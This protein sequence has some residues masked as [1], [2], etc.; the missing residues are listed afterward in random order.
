MLNM[1]NL[2]SLYPELEP[3]DSG[4][5]KVSDIHQIYYE[6]CGKKDGKPALF[7]H[8]GPGGGVGMNDRRLFDPEVYRVVL[9]DQRG[10]GKSTPP[11]E[12]K[13]NTTWNLVNDI[14]KL[15]DHLG[16]EKWGVVFGGSWGSSL[17]LIYAQ[18]HPDRVKAMVLRGIF[19]VRR[20][21]IEWFYQ[22]GAGNIYPDH[23]EK[24]VEPIPEAE[25]G[26]LIKAYYKQLTSEDRTV[27]VRAARAWSTWEM[28]TSSLYLNPEALKR[29]EDDEWVQRF[30][31]IEC[32][33]FNNDSWL[34]EETHILNNIDKIRHIPCTI[35]QGRYDLVCPM[36]SAWAL[37]KK[38]PEAELNVVPDAGHSAK[39]PGIRAMLLEATDKYGK[40]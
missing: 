5:L 17:S 23:F 34:D 33:Y 18:S 7:L 40:M 35:V 30:A 15:R 22:K 8:G 29:T 31:R 28:V 36:T 13:D 25:R 38:W 3:F 16:I 21:E 24:F 32:H 20:E 6:Q 9:L 4:M 2:R 26:N 1:D 11:A 19:L 27:R 10:A 12:L 37:H 39:E 14:E